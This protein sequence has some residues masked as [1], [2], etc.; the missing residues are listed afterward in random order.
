MTLHFIGGKT[1][2]C[3]IT[4]EGKKYIYFTAGSYGIKYRVDKESGA[5]QISPYWNTEKRMNVEF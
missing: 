2:E 3:K 1:A 4:K 5:V